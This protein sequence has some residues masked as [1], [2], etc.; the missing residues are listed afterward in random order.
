MKNTAIIGKFTQCVAEIDFACSSSSD[1]VDKIYDIYQV[2]LVRE[3]FH[4]LIDNLQK[5]YFVRICKNTDALLQPRAH[6]DV[7]F[8]AEG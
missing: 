4:H 2:L 6:D 1:R 5:L 3:T 8:I 7:I